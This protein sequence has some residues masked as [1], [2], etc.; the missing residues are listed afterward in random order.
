MLGERPAAEPSASSLTVPRRVLGAAPHR[1][2]GDLLLTVPGISITQHSGESKAYQIF[3]RGF[4]AVHG[5]DLEIWAGGAPV[6]DVSNIH[7]QGY[8]DLHFVMP[9]V[10][11]SIRAEPGSYDPRQGDFAVAGSVY[12]DFG[13]DE[14]GVMAKA[15]SGSYGLRRY[16]LAY[17]P[18]DA[19]E[20]TFAAFE[21][22]ATD[23][24]GP[25]RAA[26]RVSGMAQYKTM[27]AEHLAV[28]VLGTAYATRFDSAGVLRLSDI[29][30]GRVDRF[31]SYDP[32]QGGDSTRSSLVLELGDG[33]PDSRWHLAPYLIWRTLTLRSNFTGYLADPAN[34]D[35]VQQRNDASTFGFTSSYRLPLVLLSERDGL[36]VG[37]SARS[38]SIEQSQRRL[39]VVDD[40]VTAVDV[41]ARVHALDTAGFAELAASPHPRVE[42]RA[43]M[44][45]D[46]LYYQSEDKGGAAAGQSRSTEGAHLG[47]KANV[48]VLLVEGLSAVASYGEGFRSP[49]ARSLAN[50]QK[51]PFT[52]VTSFEAGFRY[53]EPGLRASLAGFH[54]LLGED[55]VFDHF[56]ARN[57][58]VPGTMRTGLA[59]EMTALP[60]PWLTSAVSATYTRAEFRESTSQYRKGDLLPYVPQ[61]VVRADLAFAPVL[62]REG[63][64][65]LVG[66]L[67]AGGTYLGRRPLPYAEMGHDVFVIDARAGVRLRELEVELE[68]FNAL[69]TKYYDGEFVYASH[70]TQGG[71]PSLVPLRHVTVGP[72]RIVVATLTLRV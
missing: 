71:Q 23:G 57:E 29:E 65:D 15:S 6:N 43:G 53:R 32:K 42:L 34:G 59:A 20:S 50:G 56:T 38:D 72:P 70:F 21:A 9:E 62:R 13:D 40:R 14:P 44:R 66:K 64:R 12:L 55:L 63:T 3:Y 47:K 49:Q 60:R 31:A 46:G 7:G 67:G 41:D 10:V 22:Y 27:L 61:W 4:D 69:D 48:S 19:D 2:G 25:S 68:T 51:T 37:V 1:T 26:R 30:S 17:R 45:I 11:R 28:R 5:Q 33:R 8:A 35:S 58:A 52:D 39:A 16:F 54:T 36:E 24:F 18:T